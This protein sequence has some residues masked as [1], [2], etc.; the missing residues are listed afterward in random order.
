LTNVVQLPVITIDDLH[1]AV[2]TG[3]QVIDVRDAHEHEKGV[4][5]GAAACPTLDF[6]T[7]GRYVATG[8]VVCSMRKW[9]TSHY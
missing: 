4:I 7:S 1:D 8:G 3:A 2:A 6:G 5:D 9:S